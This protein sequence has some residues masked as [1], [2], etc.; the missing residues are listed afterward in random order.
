MAKFGYIA[1]GGERRPAKKVPHYPKPLRRDV[2]IPSLDQNL[3]QHLANLASDVRAAR[4][5]EPKLH[6]QRSESLVRNVRIRHHKI[7]SLSALA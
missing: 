1:Q 4:A 2:G 7:V 5:F 6:I 3:V